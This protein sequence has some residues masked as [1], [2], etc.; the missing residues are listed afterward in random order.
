MKSLTHD[1]FFV[2]TWLTCGCCVCLVGAAAAGVVEVVDKVSKSLE[3]AKRVLS[4]E[5][6]RYIGYP[7]TQAPQEG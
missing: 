3:R 6:I 2:I 7:V 4:H 5:N 1:P